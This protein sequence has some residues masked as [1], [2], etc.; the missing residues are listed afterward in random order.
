MNYIIESNIDFYAE[1]QKK[2]HEENVKI[3]IISV[4]DN[5]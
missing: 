5:I 4:S 1:L 2:I 3:N